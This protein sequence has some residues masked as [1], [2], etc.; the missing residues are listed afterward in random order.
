MAHL[1]HGSNEEVHD[2]AHGGVVVQ[3][4]EG[5]H[6]QALA[7]QHD[8]D[9]DQ[10]D[11]LKGGAG[12]LEG[13]TQPGELDLADAGEGDAKDN[14][15]NVEQ[16]RGAG[17][18]DTPGP[19]GEEHGD[20]RGRLEHLDKGDGEVEV[21]QVGADEGARVDEPDGQNRA[22]VDAAIE[23]EAAARLEERR[24]AGEDLG[25]DGGEDEMPAGEEDGYFLVGWLVTRSHLQ[26]FGSF[27]MWR[28]LEGG[29]C[30]YD[31]LEE[32]KAL[33]LVFCCQRF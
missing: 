4:D 2:G 3:T 21:D 8:L 19:R 22:Q 26:V 33:V 12:E 13:K 32:R 17:V 15:E 10:T 1:A 20:G 16:H 11:G 24:G 5:I 6:P 7:A 14:D 25:C 23:L 29:G 27:A 28:L 9:H 18:G 31:I 30:T